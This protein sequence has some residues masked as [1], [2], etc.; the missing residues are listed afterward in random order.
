MFVTAAVAAG[1]TVGPHVANT[2][3]QLYMI[4]GMNHCQ[5]GPGTDTFDKMAAIEQS[6]ILQRPSL[7][8]REYKLLS[9]ESE[10]GMIR[11][12]GWFTRRRVANFVDD[13]P[14]PVQ[15]RSRRSR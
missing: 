7:F 8:S 15:V 9:G 13:V 3:I 4:P 2:S 14:P 10:V 6:W 12:V 5:G 1:A 11:P